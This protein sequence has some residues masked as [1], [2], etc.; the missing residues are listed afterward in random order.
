[1]WKPLANFFVVRMGILLWEL[2]KGTGIVGTLGFTVKI[3][4]GD[5]QGTDCSDVGRVRYGTVRYGTIGYGTVQYGTFQY[6]K[7]RL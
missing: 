6:S 3:G 2:G 7:V 4:T 5:W 1:M